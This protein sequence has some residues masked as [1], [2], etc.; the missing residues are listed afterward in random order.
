MIMSGVLG[1]VLLALAHVLFMRE[2][3]S[4]RAARA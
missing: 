1:A 3:G 2:G 4:S